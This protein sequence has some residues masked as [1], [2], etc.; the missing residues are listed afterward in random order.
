MNRD[1]CVM[2]MPVWSIASAEVLGVTAQILV[3]VWAVEREPGREQRRD[4]WVH[5]PLLLEP[6]ALHCTTSFAMPGRTVWLSTHMQ[7]AGI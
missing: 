2:E 6:S 7:F 4:L 5:C 3:P 1:G